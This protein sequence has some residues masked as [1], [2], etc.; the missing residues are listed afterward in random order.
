MRAVQEL[1]GKVINNRKLNVLLT[2]D[3]MVQPRYVKTNLEQIHETTDSDEGV[4]TE[5]S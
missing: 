3:D 2:I 5:T 1:N 4:D